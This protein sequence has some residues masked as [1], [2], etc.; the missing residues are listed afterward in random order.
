MYF[1][2]PHLGRLG[3]LRL[4]SVLCII[5]VIHGSR[6]TLVVLDPMKCTW[7]ATALAAHCFYKLLKVNVLKMFNAWHVTVSVGQWRT[8][9]DVACHIISTLRMRGMP[10]RARARFCIPY[11]IIFSTNSGYVRSLSA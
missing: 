3:P 9:V 5:N 8:F 4:V 6:H 10:H 7:H 1:S 11:R 2:Q